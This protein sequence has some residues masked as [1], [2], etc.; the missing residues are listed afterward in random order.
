MEVEKEALQLVDSTLS[1]IDVVMKDWGSIDHKTKQKFYAR[2]ER[3]KKC[4]NVL[5]KWKQIFVS[6]KPEN[7][8]V[9]LL[10][11]HEIVGQMT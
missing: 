6:T 2:V 5:E 9:L 1:S 10:D 8:S 11:L 4:K 7:R 3:L